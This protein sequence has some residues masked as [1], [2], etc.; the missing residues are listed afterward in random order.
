MFVTL[1]CLL[2]LF[3][4]RWRKSKV[5]GLNF[6]RHERRAEDGENARVAHLLFFL[7]ICIFSQKNLV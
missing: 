6:R 2:F 5:G 3:K 7:K 4:M 1:V